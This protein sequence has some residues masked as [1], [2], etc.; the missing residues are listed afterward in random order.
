MEKEL[1]QIMKRESITK[2][3]MLKAYEHIAELFKL[4]IELQQRVKKLEN[5]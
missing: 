4:V 1:I 2:Q 5:K 3:Q